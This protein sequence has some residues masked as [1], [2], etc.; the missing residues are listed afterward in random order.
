[1][2]VK[3]YREEIDK[4]DSELAK[5]YNERMQIAKQ[6]GLEKA[7]QG[8]STQNLARE[9]E[10]I[11]K[12]TAL[13]DEDLQVFGK[14]VYETIFET[15]K[16]YQLRFANM[17][18]EFKQTI[19]NEL[20][21]QSKFPTR[22]TVACQGVEGAYSSIATNKL[23]E[24]SDILY[25]KD[26]NA[27]MTAVEKGMCEYGVLPIENSS[28]GSV[29][30]VYDLMKKHNFYIVKSTKLKV[31]HC[32]LAK[33]GAKLDSIKEI[34]SHEQAL[35]QC[36]EFIKSLGDVKITV[37]PNTAVAAKMVSEQDRT[38][39]ACI[40]SAECTK[41]YDLK[42]LKANIQDNDNNYTRFIVIS[43]ELKIFEDADKISLTLDL[44]HE[45][46]SLNKLLNK[47]STLA[48]NLTKLE[49]RPIPTSPFE[50][51]FY[52]DFDAK[53]GTNE[54]LNLLAEVESEYSGFKFLGSYKEV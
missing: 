7:R 42:T 28:A 14:R 38:D 30:A 23:F 53:I 48:L 15:S 22:A 51:E 5:L 3:N 19:I 52:F 21:K 20:E 36:A 2:D 33:Q 8:L 29:N 50:F 11:N 17:E 35:Q 54:T 12:V 34:C 18:S 10:V 25:F 9:K 39:L 45:A 44:P 24:I 47:F 16:A 37:C 41:L 49:S 40:S 46:G 13:M 32:L 1:M 27:V 26:F 6:I 4:I 31:Q 43:K